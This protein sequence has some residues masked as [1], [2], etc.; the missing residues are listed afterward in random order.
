ME[1]QWG[2]EETQ[3]DL[4]L[5]GCTLRAHPTCEGGSSL[6]GHM[7][8]SLHPSAPPSGKTL[9]IPDTVSCATAWA[10][11]RMTWAPHL[12]PSS[13]RLAQRKA[14][15]IPSIYIFLC[16]I[17]YIILTYIV[18]IHIFSFYMKKR[19]KVPADQVCSFSFFVC[20]FPTYIRGF[21]LFL[22]SLSPSLYAA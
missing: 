10:S 7:A 20:L 11:S 12:P 15:I 4:I 1:R 18:S 3:A 19:L 17:T 14:I 21:Y 8:P 22:L 2:L 16:N 13:P 5:L 9:G 6:A